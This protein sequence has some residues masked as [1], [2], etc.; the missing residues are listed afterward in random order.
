MNM[1]VVCASV[2]NRNLSIS[3][4]IPEIHLLSLIALL[5]DT[6]HSTLIDHTATVSVPPLHNHYHSIELYFTSFVI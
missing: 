3:L 2:I 1:E 6:V 5:R 4:S